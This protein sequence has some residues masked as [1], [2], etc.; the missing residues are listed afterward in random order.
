MDK[1]NEAI[2]A[3]LADPTIKALIADLGSVPMPMTPTDFGKFIAAET[4][5]WAEVI[6]FAGIEP[7]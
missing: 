7:L 4:N 5:K 3:G 6:K 1:L 2:N